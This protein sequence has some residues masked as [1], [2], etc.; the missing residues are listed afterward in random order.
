[1]TR[2][3]ANSE[4]TD[5][6][7]RTT[8]VTGATGFLGASLARR[9]LCEGVRVRVLARSRTKA[10]PLADLGA[11]VLIGDVTDQT[12]VEAAVDGRQ[13]VYH[14]AGP[15]L[16]PGIPASEYRRTHVLGTTL[17]LDCCEKA[18]GVERFV[19]CSTTGVLG[20]TGDQ[21]VG[22]DAPLRPTNVYEQAKA[23]AETEVRRRWRDCF[24]VV[25][26]RPGL[27][28]GPGDIHLL[29]FFQTIL[30]HRFRPIG[31]RQ[32][33]LHPIYIDDMTE[34]LV[35]CGKRRAAV[36]ECFHL[37]GK[38]SVSIGEL[39]SA[40]AHAEGTRLPPGSIPLSAARVVAGLGDRLPPRLKQRAPLTSSRLD[41]LT[42]SR[43]Y[44][45]SKAACLLGFAAPT[46]LPTGLA[47]T[48][49]WYRQHGY[50]PPQT[51]PRAS[52][53]EG[54]PRCEFGIMS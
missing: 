22:E 40:I 49:A 4:A 50:L 28:Y 54:V 2:L 52:T 18:P 11:E 44:D 36:G 5:T 39:A 51:E 8:L 32:A 16:V 37:A 53:E 42:H 30:R 46:D 24:P 15:L 38:E 13:V 14:L 45:I 1:M 21:P 7:C 10:K 43:V 9:L 33:R 20:V 17:L 48:V 35:L 12:A 23:D 6:P 3:A 27:V 47:R 25:I 34:A 29:P 26:A 41:F 31:R 19:Y